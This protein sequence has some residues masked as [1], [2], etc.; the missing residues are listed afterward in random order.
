MNKE[1]KDLIIDLLYDLREN[2]TLDTTDIFTLMHSIFV[3][4]YAEQKPNVEKHYREYLLAEYKVSCFVG[5]IEF[6]E[7]KAKEYIEDFI[8]LA[9]EYMR[10]INA[11][12]N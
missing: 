8:A 2:G 10:Q 6:N 9:N 12:L 1:E 3:E 11:L 5:D 7:I 4:A